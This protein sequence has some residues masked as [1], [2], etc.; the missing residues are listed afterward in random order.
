MLA[1]MSL[2]LRFEIVSTRIPNPCLFLSGGLHED[3]RSDM[4]TKKEVFCKHLGSL[5]VTHPQR[6]DGRKGRKGCKEISQML[7]L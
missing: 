3:A 6:I 5:W 4:C 2:R 1:A 7:L